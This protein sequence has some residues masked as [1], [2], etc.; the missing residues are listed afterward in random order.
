MTNDEDKV[1]E[2]FFFLKKN[3]YIV[4]RFADFFYDLSRFIGSPTEVFYGIVSCA[5]PPYKTL[6]G[7]SH[8]STVETLWSNAK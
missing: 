5:C 2:N 1:F 8:S 3:Y 7:G 6:A 4:M